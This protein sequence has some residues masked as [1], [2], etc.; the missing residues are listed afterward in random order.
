MCI[1]DRLA[2]EVLALAALRRDRL[3]LQLAHLGFELT[4]CGGH[5]LRLDAQRRGHVVPSALTPTVVLDGGGRGDRLD[6]ACVG[7]HRLAAQDLEQADLRRRRYVRTTAQLAAEIVDLEDAHELPV[8]LL[9]QSHRPDLS[10]VFPG[11]HKRAHGVVLDDAPVDEVLDLAQLGGARRAAHAEVEAQA[12]GAHHGAALAHVFAE[13]DAQGV[14]KEVRRRVIAGGLVPAYRVDHGLGAL[15]RHHG[16]LDAAGDDHL[17]VLKAHHFVDLELA[18]VGVDP[19]RVRDL[20][21]ALGVER[22]FG[23]LDG[24][25][26]VGE[27][28]AHTDHGE[29]LETLVADERHGQ[30]RVVA[31]ELLELAGTGVEGARRPLG[32]AGALALLF[33]E[34]LEALLVDAHLPLRGD[35]AGEV[36]GKTVGVVQF[37]GD[38]RRQLRA[39]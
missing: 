38:L 36:E 20:T 1:R 27:L 22:R 26:A 18:R 7:A 9:E 29:D 19:A 34:V 16:A 35:L 15:A 4:Y 3:L 32:G 13:H 5:A 14:V 37:E 31:L 6:A 8:L 11:G 25:A 24:H 17:V 12:L 30:A 39:L 2:G 21:A 33:H 28:A 10:R 23:E